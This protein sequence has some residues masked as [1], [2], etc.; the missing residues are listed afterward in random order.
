M[1]KTL[2]NLNIFSFLLFLL[3]FYFCSDENVNEPPPPYEY[4]VPEQT[5][6]G[7]NTGTLTEVNIQSE[8]LIQLVDYIN[9]GIFKRVHCVIIVRQNKL[10]F[11]EY[12]S[13]H[14]FDYSATNHEGIVKNFGVNTI[15][16]QASVTKSFASALVGIAIDKGFI[17]DEDEKL[18]SFF[19]E[20]E[21]Y[22]VGMKME[23]TL[24][25]LLTMSAGF[26]WNEHDLSYGNQQNDLI[27]MWNVLDPLEYLI[28]KPLDSTPGTKFYYNSGCTNLLGEI[29]YKASGI[30]PDVFADQY[31]FSKLGIVDRS[32]EKF[33]NGVVFVSGDLRIRPR[34]MAKFGCL[35]LN[36]GEWNNEQIISKEWIDK[37]TSA[38]TN[39]P[40]DFKY[41]Y[42]WWIK[43]YN[44]NEV[45]YH[46]FSA[47]GWGGQ[48]ISAFPEL[49]M[50]I[51]FTGGNYV[52]YD[53]SDEII[54][55][56]IL[57]SVN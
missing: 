57:P 37:S 46:S 40:I 52:D 2:T 23:I 32:W 39:P 43:N 5:D 17:K 56:F 4:S 50:V 6:D 31:L 20:Y 10:V 27:Q 54:R 38:I 13:G 49:D 29:V 45:E 11:E 53:P 30:K 26:K 34:D 19:P 28:S 18:F 24:K 25:H 12:F 7:W 48:T 47:R 55:D 33:S 14:S 21:K 36:K 44:F 9:Y 41:G 42:Q 1:K 16:N 51:V 8:K 3:L 22:N 15:H 35:Y